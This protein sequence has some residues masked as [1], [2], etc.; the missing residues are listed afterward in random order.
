MGT[1]AGG[2]VFALI[3]GV[4]AYAAVRLAFPEVDASL[5]GNLIG[6]ASLIG[7][8]LGAIGMKWWRRRRHGE[9]P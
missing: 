1:L 2:G 4:L 6:I 3:A 5:Y 8:A 9:P 7:G